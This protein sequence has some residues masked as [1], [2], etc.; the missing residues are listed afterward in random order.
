M[1]NG[2][3]WLPGKDD[4]PVER[5]LEYARMKY[6]PDQMTGKVFARTAD[7]PGLEED[8]SIM[9]GLW[10]VELSGDGRKA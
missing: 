5:A 8:P 6:G 4:A 3:L 1:L 9:S 10:L 2:M 7:L